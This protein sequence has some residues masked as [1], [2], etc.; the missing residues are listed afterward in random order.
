MSELSTPSFIVDQATFSVNDAGAALDQAFAVN[1]ADF[2]VAS[3][4]KEPG[5]V[6]N[7]SWDGQFPTDKFPA[8][9]GMPAEFGP[10]TGSNDMDASVRTIEV[11]ASSS[12][13]EP[14][15]E[16]TEPPPTP[17]DDGQDGVTEEDRAHAAAQFK[18]LFGALH[19]L[20]DLDAA[21]AG[22]QTEE[23]APDLSPQSTQFP[24][25]SPQS[26]QFPAEVPVITSE[27][28]IPSELSSQFS[29]PTICCPP[30]ARNHHILTQ[31]D[32]VITLGRQQSSE[33]FEQQSLLGDMQY[34]FQLPPP[35]DS[36]RGTGA[37]LKAAASLRREAQELGKAIEVWAELN[38]EPGGSLRLPGPGPDTAPQV[39]DNSVGAAPVVDVASREAQQSDT[40][41]MEAVEIAAEL[42]R[43]RTSY[44]TPPPG[45]QR[46]GSAGVHRMGSAG[47]S[48]SSFA[49]LPPTQPPESAFFSQATC[50]TAMD[51]AGGDQAPA[52]PSTSVLYHPSGLPL[53]A[54][55]PAQAQLSQSAMQPY[56]A[57]ACA[58]LAS[59]LQALQAWPTHGLASARSLAMQQM[60]AAN[61][62]MNPQLVGGTGTGGWL[63]LGLAAGGA[64]SSSLDRGST[65]QALD[66]RL[67][68]PDLEAAFGTASTGPSLTSLNPNRANARLD[69]LAP[70]QFAI[71][72]AD[73][74]A[75]DGS[76]S[77]TTMSPDPGDLYA[78][79]GP[80]QLSGVPGGVNID[81]KPDNASSLL[82]YPSSLLPP[83][84]SPAMAA[85]LAGQQGMSMG[86][87]SSAA[88]P[89]NQ[90]PARTAD[91]VA[92]SLACSSTSGSATLPQASFGSEAQDVQ[93]AQDAS[94]SPPPCRPLPRDWR[95]AGSEF[96]AS[97][98]DMTTFVSKQDAGGL[99][100]GAL[101]PDLQD[102]Q[103]Q[104][105]M[106]SEGKPLADNVVKE[107]RLDWESHFAS[108]G[109]GTS[110]A[111][112]T[113]A[114]GPSSS[115]HYTA[116]GAM[117][118]P[119]GTPGLTAPPT[120]PP[121]S[122][123]PPW[124]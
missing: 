17:M 22:P 47:G 3:K 94:L 23:P 1:M 45:V 70:N 103:F 124:S 28:T 116:L 18:D 14:A 107:Q 89:L 75:I 90:R 42:E 66:V 27:A 64:S 68:S 97:F 35:S 56:F 40:K 12:Q 112:A 118:G 50:G 38:T 41:Q 87:S 44:A 102:P 109:F 65:R 59:D 11:I 36:G 80:G 105:H 101:S 119:W 32:P 95:G 20:D 104:F 26:S 67:Q 93:S 98:G 78:W 57:A 69:T 60:L 73:V 121:T 72:V 53:L 62:S 111:A 16:P 46:M 55:A 96:T 5:P 123:Q 7:T 82:N 48:S 54:Q 76:R 117:L 79:G 81:A 10:S 120:T 77:S 34:R 6:P 43:L 71:N 39:S 13:G 37:I 113:A 110:V 84:T 115:E 21:A 58:G 85:L 2:A 52:M 61:P 24:A 51:A 9:K 88:A 122:L 99:A 86:L 74:S 114:T 8:P 91:M 33:N 49:A 4:L 29:P 30:S 106:S 15:P 108:R 25:I 83:G 31:S 63:P 92:S 100:T 19:A